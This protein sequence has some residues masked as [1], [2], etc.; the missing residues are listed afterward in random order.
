M[1]LTSHLPIRPVLA[2][3]HVHEVEQRLAASETAR[4]V[5]HH[6]WR[7]DKAGL[8]ADV[9][10]ALDIGIHAH[11]DADIGWHVNNLYALARH[12]TR[13]V[14]GFVERGSAV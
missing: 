5:L 2:I 13:I 7:R 10:E 1:M 6:A 4:E 9:G 14:R 11:N 8:R 3:P 12:P